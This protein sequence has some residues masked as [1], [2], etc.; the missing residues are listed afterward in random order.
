MF[1]ACRAAMCI[2]TKLATTL[3]PYL[4]ADALCCGAKEDAE[5]IQRELRLALADVHRERGAHELEYLALD[6]ALRLRPSGAA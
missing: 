6:R 2:D 5:G 3:L 4:V 1:R